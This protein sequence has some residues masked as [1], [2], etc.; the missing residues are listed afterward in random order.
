MRVYKAGH[1]KTV[2]HPAVRNGMPACK[3]AAGFCHLFSAAAQNLA[4]NVQIHILWETDQIQRGLYLAAH[5]V[6][7]AQGICGSDLPKGVWVIH[8]RREKVYGLH[9]R[10]VIRNA[11]NCGVI[12]A[13]V[14]NQKIRIF[15]A[16]GQLFQ[17]T[18]QHPGTQLCGAAA[19]GTEYDLII[20]A[21]AR[22][23]SSKCVSTHGM[24]C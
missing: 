9:Q 24:P 3:A 21:H 6:D 2:F 1:G 15:F 14:A 5:S 16:P 12:P 17:N 11:V 18:A 20:L 7:I 19:P 8:H 22:S 10:N 4:Q 23:S 13:V